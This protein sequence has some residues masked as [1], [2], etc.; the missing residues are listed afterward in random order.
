MLSAG[1]YV[2]FTNCTSSHP[3]KFLTIYQIWVTKL[4]CTYALM[5][6]NALM[7]SLCINAVLICINAVAMH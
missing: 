4:F 2:H 6:Y 7:L 3:Y 5:L 1:K